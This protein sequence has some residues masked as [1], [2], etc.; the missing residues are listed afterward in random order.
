M[1]NT[2]TLISRLS[3]RIAYQASNT[4]TVW[5]KRRASRKN[6]LSLTLG[7]PET[8]DDVHEVQE[9]GVA[10]T[11][12]DHAEELHA[13]LIVLCAHGQ[14]GLRD[15][16][17]G[18]IAQQVIRQGTVPV[19]FIRPAGVK[20]PAMNPVRRIL[21]PLDGSK[22][23]EA[24]IP[25]AASLAAQCSAQIW[26]LTVAP[27]AETLPVKAAIISRLLPLATIA[28]L[29]SL[30]QQAEEY[31]H[32]IARDLLARGALVSGAVLRGDAAAK[33]M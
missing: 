23:H 13:D 14:G 22:A 24:A 32:R 20:D 11:I 15:A 25:V 9:A 30:S 16:L 28:S 19:L 10:R 26:L 8:R 27:T 6:G 4:P 2:C 18:S 5:P 17:F 3:L 31:L 21:I 7:E 29:E 12:R 33:L 1:K